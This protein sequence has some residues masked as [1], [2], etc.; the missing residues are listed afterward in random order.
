[1]NKQ[2]AQEDFFEQHRDA[3]K[4]AMKVVNAWGRGDK[5]LP[6]L[7]GEALVDAYERGARG[8]ALQDEPSPQKAM[9]RRSRPVPQTRT[10]VR[11]SR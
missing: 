6:H 11:R 7:I 8:E 1:M 4:L 2:T 10:V 3:G 5:F 9:V